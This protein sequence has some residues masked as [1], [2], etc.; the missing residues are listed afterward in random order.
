MIGSSD[1]MEKYIPPSF[2]SGEKPDYSTKSFDSPDTVL[3]ESVYKPSKFGPDWDEE[4]QQKRLENEDKVF[5]SQEFTQEDSLLTNIEDYSRIVREDADSYA[6]KTRDEAA[7]IKAQADDLMKTL[8]EKEDKIQEESDRI[9]Q[10]ARAEAERIVDE[11][12]SVGYQDGLEQGMKDG[13]NESRQHA[14]NLLYLLEEIQSLRQILLREYEKELVELSLQV[15][16]KII[17]K[18]LAQYKDFT[19][20]Q[21]KR[22]LANLDGMGKVK[23]RVHPNE[24]QHIESHQV[25]LKPYLDDQQVLSFKADPG[26]APAST[27]IETDFSVVDL[28]L[29]KQF[30]LIEKELEHLSEERSLLFQPKAEEEG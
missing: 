10:E 5:S 8:K 22:S 9:I 17:H 14:N 7:Q 12:R 28:E 18:D 23:I 26:L 16:K 2:D 3:G 29:K 13:M 30:E 15:A 20:D 25:D 27:I 24:Y 11:G 4:Q 19:L 21:L 6:K 1:N